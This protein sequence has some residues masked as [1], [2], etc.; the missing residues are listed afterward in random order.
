[1]CLKEIKKGEKIEEFLTGQ[2]KMHEGKK[3]SVFEDLE[4]M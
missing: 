1:V 3:K 4:R 2:A